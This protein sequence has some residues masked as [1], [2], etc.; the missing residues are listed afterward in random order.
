MYVD[1]E[2]MKEAGRYQ[3]KFRLRFRLPYGKYLDL[4]NDCKNADDEYFGRWQR[5]DA[6]GRTASPIELLVLGALR[7]L[8]RGWTFDDIEES[9]SVSKEVHRVFF[10]RFIDFGSTVLY[11]KYVNMP[12][13]YAE[14]K[15]HMAEYAAAGLNGGCGSSDCCHVLH[16]KCDYNLRQNHLGG[17][18]SHTTRTF[19]TTVNHRHR[20]LHTKGG[21][22]R[23]NDQT[24]V[25]F[26]EFVS[27]IK[28]GTILED[29][30][31]ELF[32]RDGTGK[33]TT[34]KYRG[35]YVIVDNGYL[36]WSVTVPPFKVTNK[37][38]EIRWSKWVESMRK[39]VECTFGILKGRWRILKTGI[40]THDID[41]VDKVW[42]TCCALHNWLL[43]IDGLDDEWIGGVRT[44]DWTGSMG[45][46]DFE[47]V[48]SEIPN[49]IARL[50]TN[51]D[52]RNYD[53]SGMGPGSDDIGVPNHQVHLDLG[54]DSYVPG[55][56][57]Y[58]PGT[59]VRIVNQLGL[60]FFR[61]KLV[62]HF[63]ILWRQNRIV[64]PTRKGAQCPIDASE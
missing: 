57:A 63:D 23:W 42:K 37:E 1:N 33:I 12:L 38:T 20:I 5:P 54:L 62:D 15:R 45:E 18:D 27:G 28:D 55:P 56:S 31:F 51:L 47:G 60:G 30:E 4:V 9:T 14:A 8:G 16:E 46:H 52:P 11:D 21:P 48:S 3:D 43:E 17:K 39:D 13:T 41:S 58:V 2:L 34:A 19:S 44:S 50:S 29:V 24:M 61:Q 53:I 7:Y 59:E 64:W 6:T 22:G 49:A 32:E 10:H 26:D 40:R 36:R 25:R 35:G